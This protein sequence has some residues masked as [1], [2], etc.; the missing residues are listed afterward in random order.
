MALPLNLGVGGL[1]T[2]WFS[3]SI[4]VV[5]EISDGEPADLLK[6]EIRT[7]YVP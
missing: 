6:A 4:N 3:L 2:E 5:L 7:L 1:E